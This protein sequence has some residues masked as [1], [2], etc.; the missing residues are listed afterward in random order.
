MRVEVGAEVGGLC[1]PS[2]LLSYLYRCIHLYTSL[3]ELIAIIIGT[4]SPRT[5]TAETA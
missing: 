3:C 1:A 5:A 2:C 4:I